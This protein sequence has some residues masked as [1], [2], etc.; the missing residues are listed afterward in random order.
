VPAGRR[1]GVE[2]EFLLVDPATGTPRPAADAALRDDDRRPG[3]SAVEAEML[4]QQ[5]ETATE[6]CHEA[7]EVLRRVRARRRDASRRARAGGVEVVALAGSPLPADTEMTGSERYRRIRDRFGVLAEQQLTCGCHVHVE[8]TDPGPAGDGAWPAEEAVAVL[9]RLRPWLPP[10]LALSA[11]SPF[12]RGED[13]GYASYRSQ[14]WSR[15]PSSGPTDVFGS[16]AAYRRT[17]AA[18]VDTGT[19]LDAGM[20]YFDARPARD[21]PT[22]EV[23]VA[24][25]CLDPRD[26]TLIAVLARAL[27]ETAAERWRAG[28][29]PAPVRTELIRLAGWRAGRSGLGGELLDPVTARPAPAADVLGTLL[30]HAGP[31]LD[32]AGDGELA[33]AGV[34]RLLRAGTG[35]D[36]QRAI[37]DGRPSA[38]LVAEAVR[39]TLDEG[40][41]PDGPG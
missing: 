15:W 9:D 39:L 40:A 12:W 38:E 30:E 17:L 32:R 4:R 24:D 25:V 23:R 35:A 36:T 34:A 7:S 19:V 1:I 21:Y 14:V 31:A 22:L 8:L 37:G 33:R 5:L 11:N 13:T 41:E 16:P 28:E 2:E 26:T 18:M 6:P 27:V 3:P 20:A 29:P 10:L